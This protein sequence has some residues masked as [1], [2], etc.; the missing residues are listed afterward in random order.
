ML[1]ATLWDKLV[2]VTSPLTAVRLVAPCNVPAP[3]ARRAVTAVE[4]NGD[5][6]GDVVRQVSV[7]DQAVDG[8]QCG[9]ALQGAAARRACCCQHG[10]V[11]SADEVAE[12]VFNPHD[13]LLGKGGACRGRGGR[14]GLNGES[15]GGRWSD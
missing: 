13:G 9:G 14:L 15:A 1:V 6:G 12:G 10:A 8:G 7:A 11:I 2:K 5:G 3:A 4:L